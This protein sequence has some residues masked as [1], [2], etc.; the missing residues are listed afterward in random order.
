MDTRGN[1]ELIYLNPLD[2]Q[3]WSLAPRL[4]DSVLPLPEE[5][6]EA[7]PEEVAFQ[8]ATFSSQDFPLSPSDQ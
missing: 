6:G 2:S 4:E 1:F 3:K 8:D 7:S 5:H